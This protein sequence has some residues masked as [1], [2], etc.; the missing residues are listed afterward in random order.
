MSHQ[1]KVWDFWLSSH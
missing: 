1:P